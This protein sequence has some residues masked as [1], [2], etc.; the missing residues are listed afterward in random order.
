MSPAI[1]FLIRRQL[2]DSLRPSTT[3]RRGKH[4]QGYRSFTQKAVMSRFRKMILF[5][6]L[7]YVLIS[8]TE[9]F[10]QDYLFHDRWVGKLLSENSAEADQAVIKVFQGG[11]LVLPDLIKIAASEKP[12][13]GQFPFNDY[14]SQMRTERPT[15]GIVSLYL[16]QAICEKNLFFARP[17][18]VP[19]DRSIKIHGS[20]PLSTP[21]CTGARSEGF[22]WLVRLRTTLGPLGGSL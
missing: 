3:S 12:F 5:S 9:L 21:G 8:T 13:S 15:V 2:N 11:I 19:R 17:W 10:A 22:C 16:M 20:V 1:W 6:I 18:L 14:E 7:G 4:G